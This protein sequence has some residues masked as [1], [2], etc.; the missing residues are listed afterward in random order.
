MYSQL[1][2]EEDFAFI[3]FTTLIFLSFFLMI[4]CHVPSQ[5]CSYDDI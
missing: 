4:A 2:L 1:P 5:F 3:V